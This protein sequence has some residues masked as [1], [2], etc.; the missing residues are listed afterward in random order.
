MD[1]VV[2]LMLRLQVV[3]VVTWRQRLCIVWKRYDDVMSG[4]EVHIT[5]FSSME[6]TRRILRC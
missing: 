6:G 4:E 1:L 5:H 2:F 3:R